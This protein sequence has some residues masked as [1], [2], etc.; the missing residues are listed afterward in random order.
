MKEVWKEIFAGMS[1]QMAIVIIVI[2]ALAILTA[3]FF[4][5][6]PH[7]NV[8]EELVEESIKDQSGLNL[9]LSPTSPES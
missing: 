6:Y 7:E 4:A 2:L 9:D 8:V 1:K 3:S 5:W